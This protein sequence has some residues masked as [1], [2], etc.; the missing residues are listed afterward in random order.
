MAYTT[1]P[2]FTTGAVL[3]AAQM[4]TLSDD[5]EYLYGITQGVNIPFSALVTKRDINQSE[6][7]WYMRHMHRYLHFKWGV[8]DVGEGLTGFSIHVNGV[9]VHEV[10]VSTGE[11]SYED[12]TLEPGGLTEPTI[13]DFYS[14]YIEAAFDQDTTFTLYY[15]LESDK[16]TL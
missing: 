3:T 2:T 7:L 14:I 13:G 15:F 8:N 1:P 12:F 16:T 6:N 9:K 4:N 5:I 11:A 10:G